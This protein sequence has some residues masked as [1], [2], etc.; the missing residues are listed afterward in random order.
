MLYNVL[1]ELRKEHMAKTYVSLDLETTGL[2]PM[3]DA[4]IEIGALRF[5]GEQVLETFSTFVNPGRKIPPF[6]TELTGITNANVEN[7]PGGRQATYKLAEFVGRDPVVGH[8][9]GFDLAFLRQHNVLRGNPSIDTFDLAGI[10][11]PHAGRYSL[12]NLVRELAIDLPEQTH[13]ALD[14]AVMAHA[15]FMALMGR[16][17]QLPQQTLQEI[18]QLGQRIQWG[19]SN[20]FRDAQYVRQRQGFSGGIGAQLASKRGGDAAGPLFDVDDQIYEPLEPRAE[21]RLIDAEALSALLDADGPLAEAFA[22]YEYRPQQMEMLQA[23]VGAFNEKHHLLVEAGTGTGKSLAYLLPAIEWAVQNRQ[24]VVISTNTINLQEQLANKDLPTLT[25]A[26]YEFK[27]LVLKGRSHYLCRQQFQALRR[28]GPATEDEMRVLA[29]VLLWLPNTLDG[30]GDGLFLPTGQEQSVWHT[31]SAAN[32]TCDPEHCSFYQSERCFFYR[33]RAKAEGAHILIVNHALLLADIAVQNRVLPEYDVLVID[34]AHHLERATTEALR[35]TVSWPILQ[36]VFEDLLS[37][38]QNFPGLLE[39]VLGLA[40][41]QPRKVAAILQDAVVRLQDA[42]ERVQ[43]QLEVLFSEVDTFLN[44]HVDQNDSYSVRLRMTPKMRAES[45]WGDVMQA[46][47]QVAPHFATVVDALNQL[48]SGLDELT[49]AEILGFETVHA[50]LLGITRQLAEARFQLG[51]F[52]TTPQ[53]NVIYWLE[54]QNNYPFTFN[55]VPLHV[56]AL[57]REYLFDKKRSVILTSA[58]M[59]VENSFDYMRERLSAHTA[60]EL[61]VG[62]PFDYQSAALL[63]VVTDVPEPRNH[64]YQQIVDQTLIDLFRATQ[65]RALALFT[66]YIQLK[67][68]AQAIT[69]KLAQEGITVYAQGSGSSRAQLL[70]NFRRGE[71]AVLLGTRSFWEGVDV[72][73][74]ALSCLVIVKLPFDVPNDPIVAARSEGYEDPF[75]EYMVPE[76]I[77]RFTQGFGRLIRTATDQGIVVLMDQRVLTKSYGRRFLDSLPDPLIRQGTR[78][79]LPDIAERWLSGKPLPVDAAT[80]ADFDDGWAVPP[81]EEPPW[82]WG[83]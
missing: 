36:R 22:E 17:A 2:D 82:F 37:S 48:A 49:S 55:A 6:V 44:E 51:Q 67:A 16:A 74:E 50:R 75:N 43:H 27:H 72:P 46:W 42:G 23:V 30:D 59:R 33:A 32:E 56:G 40:E 31:I 20:F 79:Q 71:K 24:R 58:T 1:L 83:A 65:G 78:A 5:D 52:I 18:V 10:L 9:I 66:S 64:G 25:E 77:L 39:T 81:P 7:A 3:R 54:S 28:R 60:A 15:L 29:K 38:R 68:T 62:S 13:R 11:V 4:I 34:E 19:P 35:F 69:G 47:A 70:D 41:G 57:I 80:G 8:N 73:G 21:P 14:D 53:E 45:S 61:A 26:L 76:A 12:A 63:Y